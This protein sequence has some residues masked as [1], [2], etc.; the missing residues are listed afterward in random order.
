M[1]SRVARTVHLLLLATRGA[2]GFIGIEF[3]SKSLVVHRASPVRC[4]PRVRIMSVG[5]KRRDEKWIQQGIELYTT[6]LR[7]VL[8]VECTFVKD[9]AALVLAVQKCDDVAIILDERGPTCNSVQF[10]ERLF[11]AL[12]EGGS[13]MSFFIGGAEGLPPEL[14]A[15]RKRLLS[16]GSLTLTHQM[17]RLILVEQVYRAT[18]IRRGSGYHKD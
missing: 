11:T 14:K 5:S 16:L 4:G 12:E 1:M 7:P 2:A 6:R 8:D 18:E 17:A 13:R 3:A 9:D 15:D 10:S